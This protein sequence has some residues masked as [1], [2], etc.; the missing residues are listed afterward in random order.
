METIYKVMFFY[1]FLCASEEPSS[2]SIN[3]SV[4]SENLNTVWI[5]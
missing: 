2:I 1:S 4:Q 5:V 3:L